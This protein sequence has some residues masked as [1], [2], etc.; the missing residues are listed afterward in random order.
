MPTRLI[1][2]ARRLYFTWVVPLWRSHESSAFTRLLRNTDSLAMVFDRSMDCPEG[3]EPVITVFPC[4]L[5]R[6]V[7]EQS[8]ALQRVG[9]PLLT[10]PAAARLHFRLRD[11]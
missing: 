6:V 10:N 2:R 1:V 8:L 3:T 9:G 5:V 11:S 4:G 7:W